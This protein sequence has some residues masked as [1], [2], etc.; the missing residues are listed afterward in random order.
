MTDTISVTTVWDEIAPSASEDSSESSWKTEI[1]SPSNGNDAT[2]IRVRKEIPSQSLG[3]YL[4]R[5]TS[6]GPLIVT[7]I[8]EG[9][10][11]NT[12]LSEGM[13]LVMI[14]GVACEGL[15]IFEVVQVCK[16]APEDIDVV[17]RIPLEE[18]DIGS[19]AHLE[20]L[21]HLAYIP[22][23]EQAIT[24]IANSFVWMNGIKAL[25][26]TTITQLMKERCEDKTIPD[27]LP[28]KSDLSED[29]SMN[30]SAFLSED[31]IDIEQSLRQVPSTRS[32]TSFASFA[33]FKSLGRFEIGVVRFFERC[34]ISLIL[35]D[36]HDD[37]SQASRSASTPCSL[38]EKR[39]RRHK[40][41]NSKRLYSSKPRKT[42]RRTTS[43]SSYTEEQWIPHRRSP[44]R[45]MLV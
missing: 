43:P 26:P 37:C 35:E 3:I 7:R 2:V 8:Y 27:L 24:Y 5:A 28:S 21:S 4:S 11:S 15:S 19:N 6:N 12:K 36:D 23:Q 32:A 39:A 10:F 17:A 38:A 29:T 30:D 44:D 13:E 16:E 31:G 18:T 40:R 25:I 9:P 20:Q 14:N 33:S 22:Q 41:R 42:H 45:R 34:G 1:C